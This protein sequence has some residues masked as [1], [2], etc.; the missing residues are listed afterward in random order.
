MTRQRI[1]GNIM[2]TLVTG[3]TPRTAKGVGADYRP[4][5]GR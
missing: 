2:R 1:L 3:S 5:R 4:L